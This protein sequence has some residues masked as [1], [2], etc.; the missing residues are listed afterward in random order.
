LKLRDQAATRA[1]L[2]DDRTVNVRDGNRGK[3]MST[4]AGERP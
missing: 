2:M 4:T 1:R 3:N